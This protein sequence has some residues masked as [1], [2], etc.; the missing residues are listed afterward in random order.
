VEAP[1]CTL[2]RTCFGKTQPVIKTDFRMKYS[3]CQYWVH[4]ASHIT[5][6]QLS[7]VLISLHN[8]LQAWAEVDDGLQAWHALHLHDCVCHRLNFLVPQP[9]QTLQQYPQAIAFQKLQQPF[10]GKQWI[11]GK[12][13]SLH[14]LKHRGRVTQICV[15][16]LQLCKTDDANLRF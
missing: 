4:S 16:T 15:F 5:C 6:C 7:C 12:G 3:S 13:N 11:K 10:P 1:D 8:V 14:N 2:L 9:V